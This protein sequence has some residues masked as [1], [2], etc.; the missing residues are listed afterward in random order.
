MNETNLW[1]EFKKWGDVREVFIARN[2]NKRGKRYGFVRFKGV[3]DVTWLERKLDNLVVGGLKMHV[4]V[5]KHGRERTSHGKASRGRR[6][7]KG[8]GAANWNTKQRMEK[9]SYKLLEDTN[10]K[11]TLADTM[12]KQLQQMKETTL[13]VKVLMTDSKNLTRGRNLRNPS[14]T[15]FVSYSSVQLNIP[16]KEKTWLNNT[17]VGR[18]KN[19]ALFDRM[20]DDLMW[21]GGDDITP[22]YIRDDMVLLIGLTETKAAQMVKE[23]NE[24]GSSLFYSLEKSTPQLRTGYRLVWLLC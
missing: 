12:G 19:L 14:P 11:G 3:K 1:Y 20:E 6:Q 9:T 16:M 18:L 17:W 5:S 8:H 21:N 22:K 2:R 15:G 7:E 10:S 4:N 24:Q 23:A 13:Y